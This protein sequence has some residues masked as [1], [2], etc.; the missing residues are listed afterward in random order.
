[1]HGTY[2]NW[3]TKGVA[4]LVKI[5][6]KLFKSAYQAL[7]PNGIMVYS[8]C[9]LNLEEN[10]Q[11][12]EWAMQEFSLK[13]LPIEIELKEAEVGLTENTKKTIKILP[14]KNMEGFFVAKLKKA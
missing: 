6:K 12:I 8:T 13:L 10:E 7:K 5:Q 11:I 9:T 3:S 14:S 4:E 2:R 1:M